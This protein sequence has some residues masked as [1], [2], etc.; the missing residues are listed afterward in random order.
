MN[1]L[2]L[3]SV[4]T[5]MHLR[6]N[7]IQEGA[8]GNALASIILTTW[9]RAELLPR[10]IASVQAQLWTQWELIVEDDGSTDATPELLREIAH[11]DMRIRVHR[12]ANIGPAGSRNAGMMLACGDIITFL[13]SD[14]EYDDNHLQLRMSVFHQQPDVCFIHGGVRVIGQREQH[15]VPDLNDPARMIPIDQCAIGGTFFAR[16]G[17]IEG[18]GGWRSGYGED[19]DL[20]RR[21]RRLYPIH[22]LDSP[23]YLYH[24]ETEDSRCST[25][26]LH[27]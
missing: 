22:Y 20:L 25:L 11:G 13:D 15:F 4:I 9:N 17:V 2:Q 6:N 8:G 23:T 7:D 5:D 24:R 12:H 3:N 21:V 10:A 26:L 19:S 16:R 14:D 18:A 1:L 27:E